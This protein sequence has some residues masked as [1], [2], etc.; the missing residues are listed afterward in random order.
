[1]TQAKTPWWDN[2]LNLAMVAEYLEDDGA[3]R[4]EIIRMLEKPWN[5][6]DE[7][8]EARAQQAERAAE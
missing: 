3:D 6:D 5:Y 2:R 4:G 1:M 8:N 7:Y